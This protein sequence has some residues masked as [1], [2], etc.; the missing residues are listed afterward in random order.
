M[1]GRLCLRTSGACCR[2]TGPT[3]VVLN[4]FTFLFTLH[5]FEDIFLD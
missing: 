4:A 3:V 1:C 5:K 2:V